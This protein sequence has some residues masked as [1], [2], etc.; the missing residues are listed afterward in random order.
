M[1]NKPNKDFW[2]WYQEGLDSN[3]ITETFC[4]THDGGYDQMSDEERDE[5]EEGGDPC[6]TVT[7]VIYLG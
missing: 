4:M 3:W 2:D 6:M 7:R 5:W 1:S